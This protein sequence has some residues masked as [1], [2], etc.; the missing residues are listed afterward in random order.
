[1]LYA[2]TN[3]GLITVWETRQNQCVLHWEADNC[4]ISKYQQQDINDNTNNNNDI[5]NNNSN[6]DN[7]IVVHCYIMC[8]ME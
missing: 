4:E 8:L 5:D 1:M 2:G 6:S 7:R 3:I